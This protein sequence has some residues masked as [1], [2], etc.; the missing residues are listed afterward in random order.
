[1]WTPLETPFYTLHVDQILHR[2]HRKSRKIRGKSILSQWNERNRQQTLNTNSQN[3]C[4][5]TYDNQNQ[6]MSNPAIF[7][8]ANDKLSSFAAQDINAIRRPENIFS[9]NAK[10]TEKQIILKLHAEKIRY[11]RSRLQ[12]RRHR[13]KVR[14]RESTMKNNKLLNSRS[15]NNTRFHSKPVSVRL[16]NH[17]IIPINP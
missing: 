12:T 3:D 7:P 15:Q 5:E 14:P 13:T 10:T 8:L 2:V 1:M 4:K 6:A 17:S 9:F 11:P 16:N